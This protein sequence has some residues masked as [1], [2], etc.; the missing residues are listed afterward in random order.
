MSQL[1]SIPHFPVYPCAQQYCLGGSSLVFVPLHDP[2]VTKIRMQN[3]HTDH[4]TVKQLHAAQLLQS[5][6]F[7]VSQTDLLAFEV[8]AS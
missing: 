2:E 8:H 5:F 1:G 4:H 3:H 6:L 7:P